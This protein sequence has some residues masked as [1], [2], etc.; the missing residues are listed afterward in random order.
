MASN[1]EIT[2]P[3]YLTH[4]SKRQA[5]AAREREEFLRELELLKKRRD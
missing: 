5:Q 2:G 1:T 3:R 4:K